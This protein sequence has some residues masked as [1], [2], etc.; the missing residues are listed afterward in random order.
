[1]NLFCFTLEGSTDSLYRPTESKRG[2]QETAVLPSRPST[3]KSLQE[4]AKWRGSE[5]CIA[6]LDAQEQRH[7]SSLKKAKRKSHT[8]GARL[9]TEHEALDIPDC[10]N[11]YWHTSRPR[12]DWV[13]I[14]NGHNEVLD[15]EPLQARLLPEEDTVR[16]LTLER[17]ERGQITQTVNFEAWNPNWEPSDSRQHDLAWEAEG[18]AGEARGTLKKIQKLVR[19]KRGSPNSAE[20]AKT[21]PT[22]PTK[23]TLIK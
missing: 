3:S 5:P 1:M 4:K 8:P 14:K 9:S 13:E 6:T 10:T 7:T 18:E 20:E 16:Q 19:V 15:N 23:V 2:F 12:E 17:R 21:L 22:T 11:A